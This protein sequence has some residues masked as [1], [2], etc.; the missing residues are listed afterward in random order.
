MTCRNQF[1]SI[2]FS[3]F[4]FFL[5][6]LFIYTTWKFS[7]FNRLFSSVL[8]LIFFLAYFHT[9]LEC[10]KIFYVL[11][12]SNIVVNTLN[13]WFSLYVLK[14][15]GGMKRDTED[16]QFWVKMLKYAF[17]LSTYMCTCFFPCLLKYFF[18]VIHLI[19]IVQ[20]TKT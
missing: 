17:P 3:P 7:F 16:S 19:R 5:G 8:N 20:E 12:N 4:Y 18:L 1:L 15:G 9:S 14:R 2:F 11:L 13:L 10:Q 6:S